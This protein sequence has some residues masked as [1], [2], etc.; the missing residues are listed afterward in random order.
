[1]KV[2]LLLA[3]GAVSVPAPPMMMTSTSTSTTT[4]TTTATTATTTTTTD[5]NIKETG[6]IVRQE[7][8]SEDENDLET[9]TAVTENERE[10]IS[11]S[12]EKTVVMIQSTV[13]ENDLGEGEVTTTKVDSEKTNNDEE[14]S[15]KKFSETTETETT[16]EPFIESK[17]SIVD[18]Q[19]N[20]IVQTTTSAI[21]ET[22]LLESKSKLRITNQIAPSSYIPAAE[23]RILIAY[24]GNINLSDDDIDIQSLKA[25]PRE[26]IAVAQELELQRRGLS[27]FT[28]PTPWQMLTE[29]QQN[30]FNRKY[31]SLPLEL[32]MF[33]R[34]QFLSLSDKM[35]TKAY[36]AFL[37]LDSN[38]LELVL[39]NEMETLNKIEEQKAEIFSKNFLKIVEAPKASNGMKFTD[40]N[41]IEGFS[42]RSKSKY[43][44]RKRQFSKT[45]F[46]QRQH[47][48]PSSLEFMK[49]AEQ[50]HLKYA[51]EQLYQ[52]IKLQACLA[53]RSYC[54]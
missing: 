29:E 46:K 54:E 37:T 8:S 40:L 52:A 10:D 22:D 30:E 5:N 16:I 27:P 33:S 48:K 45:H 14:E 47:K 31:L 44:P 2:F 23:R 28:D 3:A 19:S 4:V 9:P 12:S 13:S 43:D 41:Q 17:Q 39:R 20:D 11:V 38:T 25:T 26:K 36:N 34:D 42:A 18:R 49:T 35:Q 15:L 51:K 7:N 6:F 21:E 50:L 32:R 53:N 1:M 24:L